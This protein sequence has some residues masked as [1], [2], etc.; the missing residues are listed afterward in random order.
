MARSIRNSADYFPHF[1]QPTDAQAILEYEYGNDGY[2]FWFRLQ[3]ALAGAESHCLDFS[4]NLT[5]ESFAIK[6]RLERQLM[7]TI[8]DTMARM[9][10]IDRELWESG[11]KVWIGEFVQLFKPLY[12][13]RGRDVPKKPR[14]ERRLQ[15]CEGLQ[16]DKPTQADLEHDETRIEEVSESDALQPAIQAECEVAYSD[17]YV[18]ID[19]L[20]SSYARIEHDDTS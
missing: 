5:I 16:D 13:S 19:V 4:H 17:Q 18:T 6:C 9:D 11:R 1:V 8:L 3:E 14:M 7:I 12:K 20:T 2:V 10:V 15:A